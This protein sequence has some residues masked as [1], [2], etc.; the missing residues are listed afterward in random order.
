MASI[1]EPGP[2]SAAVSRAISVAT[3]L[4][5]SRS[6][7]V[8]DPLGGRA[9]FR[10]APHGHD[11]ALQRVSLLISRGELRFDLADFRSAA[12]R[13]APLLRRL[14]CSFARANR[15]R[16]R[17]WSRVR[18]ARG[19]H[20]LRARQERVTGRPA[21]LRARGCGGPMPRFRRFDGNW[22]SSRRSRT[23]SPAILFRASFSSLVAVSASPRSRASRSSVART[24]RS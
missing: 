10:F 20:R 9:R 1:G 23:A 12:A 4:I 19:R 22:R 21:G 16:C 5:R 14:R 13:I 3:S 11:L 2:S 18:R 6:K 17:G 15:S 8:L 24:A 7:C